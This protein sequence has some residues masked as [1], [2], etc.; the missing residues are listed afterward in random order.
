MENGPF[1]DDLPVK[2]VFYHS[3]VKLSEGNEWRI[4]RN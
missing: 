4:L 2:M 1:I 3:Y